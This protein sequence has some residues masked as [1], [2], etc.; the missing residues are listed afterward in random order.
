MSECF[1]AKINVSCIT[2]LLNEQVTFRSVLPHRG[3]I[4]HFMIL[5]NNHCF[6]S[7]T[8]IIFERLRHRR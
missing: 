3:I 5:L 4:N 8:V 6:F 7:R 1:R 2:L